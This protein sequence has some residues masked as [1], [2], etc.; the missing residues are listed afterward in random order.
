MHLLV[1]FPDLSEAGADGGADV[2][3]SSRPWLRDSESIDQR[4]DL[5]VN[6]Y[7]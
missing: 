3:V 4:P 6:I 7:F 5:S 1:F 2:F